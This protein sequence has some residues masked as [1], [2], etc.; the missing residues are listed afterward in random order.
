[1]T[2]HIFYHTVTAYENVGY[3]NANDKTRYRY[4]S[5]DGSN[6]R[7]MTFDQDMPGTEC[8]EF[9]RGGWDKGPCTT[10]SL[11]PKSIYMRG[12]GCVAFNQA[13]CKGNYA[14]T[15]SPYS[16][17]ADTCTSFDSDGW[18]PV[19]SFYCWG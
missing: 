2:T 10:G 8:D 17:H 11:I 18:G 6:S 12:G 9:Q 15:N 1:M 5:G 16:D 14:A 7:C 4:I 13:G 3:C 19:R